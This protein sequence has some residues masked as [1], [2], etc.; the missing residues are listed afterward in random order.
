MIVVRPIPALARIE[1][2]RRLDVVLPMQL[3]GLLLD[4]RIDPVGNPRFRH[5]ARLP[6]LSIVACPRFASCLRL[7]FFSDPLR[8]RLRRPQQ[9]ATLAED[10]DRLRPLPRLYRVARGR[11]QALLE[12][13][14]HAHFRYGVLP[15][16]R[17][18]LGPVLHLFLFQLPLVPLDEVDLW[19]RALTPHYARRHTLGWLIPNQALQLRLTL[20]GGHELHQLEGRHALNPAIRLIEAQLMVGQHRFQEV[21]GPPLFDSDDIQTVRLNVLRCFFGRHSVRMMLAA[22]SRM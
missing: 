9:S 18:P 6:R 5:T 10:L 21:L 1:S 20:F 16:G 12:G 7:F 14:L 13:L 4:P 19:F 17:L 11:P 15:G 8:V 2:A 22:L 3:V